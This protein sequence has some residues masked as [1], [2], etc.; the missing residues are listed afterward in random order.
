MLTL[1]TTSKFRKDYK[2]MKKRGYD[3]ARL[4]EII[5]QLLRGETL[6]PKHRD[7]EL[8]GDYA[9]FRECHAQPDWLLVYEIDQDVLVLT[10]FRTGTHSDLFS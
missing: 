8:I 9:G 4:E 10:A 6:A 5:D 3:L 1:K 7:H 2:R